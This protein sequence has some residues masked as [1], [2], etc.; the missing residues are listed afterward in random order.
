MRNYNLEKAVTVVSHAVAAPVDVGCVDIEEEHIFN[1]F[2]EGVLSI[3]SNRN[4]ITIP[5]GVGGR[6]SVR[7]S[8][9]RKMTMLDE[10]GMG[11]GVFLLFIFLLI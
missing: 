7:A 8:Y 3:E 11:K 2:D 5:G 1:G 10:N 4:S 9:R 6:L